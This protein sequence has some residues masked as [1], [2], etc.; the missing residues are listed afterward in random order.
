V[1]RTESNSL[2]ELQEK[3]AQLE[4][5]TDRL[6]EA[7]EAQKMATAGVQNDAARQI[8]EMSKE[9][10]KKVMLHARLVAINES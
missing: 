6:S 4:S 2:K 1:H 3:A 8:D 7:L 10:Q 5:E 9:L